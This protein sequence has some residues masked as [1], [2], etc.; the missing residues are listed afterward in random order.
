MWTKG[1]EDTHVPLNLG[2]VQPRS[3]QLLLLLLITSPVNPR[4]NSRVGLL[5]S[6]KKPEF[7]D[8]HRLNL[9]RDEIM[10]KRNDDNIWE[11]SAH[12]CSETEQT[13]R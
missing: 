11:I 6:N 3:L 9:K 2:S 5:S 12:P 4:Q 13:R 7:H 1:S 10:S 8:V